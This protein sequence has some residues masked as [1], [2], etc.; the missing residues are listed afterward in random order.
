MRIGLPKGRFEALSRQLMANLGVS[1]DDSSPLRFRA[2]GCDVLLLKARDIPPLV[3][4]GRL[5]AGVAP[6]ELTRETGAGCRAVA[7]VSGYSAR[8]SLLEPAGAGLDLA[9]GTVDRLCVATEFPRIAEEYLRP[10]V[11]DLTILHVYGSAEA[12]APSMADAVVDCVETGSTAQAHQLDEVRVLHECSLEV[13]VGARWSEGTSDLS[14]L[15]RACAA[16]SDEAAPSADDPCSEE[17]HGAAPSATIGLH[18]QPPYLR[19]ACLPL[20]RDGTPTEFEGLGV[21]APVEPRAAVPPYLVMWDR[22][23]RLRVPQGV[24]VGGVTTAFEAWLQAGNLRTQA[25]DLFA[26]LCLMSVW[27]DLVRESGLMTGRVYFASETAVGRLHV[28]AGLDEPSAE[29]LDRLLLEAQ[30]LE[31]IYRFPVA[32]KFRGTYGGEHQC[33]LNGWGRRLVQR[34]LVDPVSAATAAEWSRA[35]RTHLDDHRD[36]YQSHIDYVGSQGLAFAPVDSWERSG[37][38]PVPLLL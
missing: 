33:R 28:H 19:A 21:V 26:L 25:P 23:T 9:G 35:L 3:A 14:A 36:V 2:A 22:T 38:L 30:S 20:L 4:S 34:A 18:S 5:T 31:L 10:L 6:S 13:I 16:M 24:G 17:E 32:F 12:F 7:T 27:D 37:A 11:D 8:V 15:L 1:G 29:H